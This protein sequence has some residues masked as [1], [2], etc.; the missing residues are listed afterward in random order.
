MVSKPKG[1]LQKQAV[2]H[3]RGKSNMM[4]H[5]SSSNSSFFLAGANTVDNSMNANTSMLQTTDSNQQQV[6]QQQHSVSF[7]QNTSNPGMG[8][9]RQPNATVKQPKARKVM[10]NTRSQPNILTASV[11]NPKTTQI[12]SIQSKQ[13]LK[14]MLING[15]G[16]TQPVVSTQSSARK[17]DPQYAQG[18]SR[19]QA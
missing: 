10:K 11:D 3:Q 12:S 1:S 7:Y 19:A 16:K 17:Y 13:S 9:S 14:Q 2:K 5:P 18:N 15:P 4:L 6:L 8:P